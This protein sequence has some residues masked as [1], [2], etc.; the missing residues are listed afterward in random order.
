MTGPLE[1]DSVGSELSTS[2]YWF[3]DTD[4][5]LELLNLASP[6]V[7][8]EMM[9]L[10]SRSY[11]YHEDSSQ[12]LTGICR[13]GCAAHCY[14]GVTSAPSEWTDPGLRGQQVWARFLALRLRDGHSLPRFTSSPTN[15]GIETNTVC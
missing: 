15:T 7:T 13:G 5:H 14:L 10:T 2:I 11:C 4:K 3:C 8:G 6:L 12:Y 9:R 1:P